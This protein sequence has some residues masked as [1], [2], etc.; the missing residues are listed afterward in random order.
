MIYP[1]GLLMGKVYHTETN[2]KRIDRMSYTKHYYIG[3]ERV[4]GK[5]GTITD[6]GFYPQNII[7]DVMHWTS[8][9]LIMYLCAV[10]VLPVSYMPKIL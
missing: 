2:R 5:T 10:Q 1:S 8:L 7:D 6:L 9:A 4:S 3:S